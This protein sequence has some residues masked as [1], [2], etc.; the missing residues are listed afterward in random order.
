[1][2]PLD[3]IEASGTAS[4]VIGPEDWSLG[5]TLLRSGLFTQSPD[6]AEIKKFQ[7]GLKKGEIAID[8][9]SRTALTP[10]DLTRSTTTTAWIPWPAHMTRYEPT[11]IGEVN[12]CLK[13]HLTWPRSRTSTT[14]AAKG[15]ASAQSSIVLNDPAFDHA[16]PR[17]PWGVTKY[18]IMDAD[19]I[20]EQQQAATSPELAGSR[21][22]LAGREAHG[23]RRASIIPAFQNIKHHSRRP[24][25][26]SLLNTHATARP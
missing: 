19:R 6:F 8:N 21:S 18:F 26:A 4:W 25:A 15:S 5:R 10:S 20:S 23:H 17:F 2:N 7:E 3:T 14:P 13:G 1:M 24:A 16:T 22:L 9:A 12:V 11:G